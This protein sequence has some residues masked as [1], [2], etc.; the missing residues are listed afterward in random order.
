MYYVLTINIV[1]ILNLFHRDGGVENSKESKK[2]CIRRCL[3]SNRWFISANVSRPDKNI[4]G[5][6]TVAIASSQCRNNSSN[7]SE[8]KRLKKQIY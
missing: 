3:A 5:N 2:F 1:F 6:P 8:C 7:E 4:W